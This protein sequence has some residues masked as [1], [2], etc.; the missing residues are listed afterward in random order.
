[1]N[2]RSMMRHETYATCSAMAASLGDT[3]RGHASRRRR[4]KDVYLPLGASAQLS[5]DGDLAAIDPHSNGGRC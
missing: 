5:V 4:A 1:M 2:M 3:S